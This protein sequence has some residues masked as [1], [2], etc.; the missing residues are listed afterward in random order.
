M[1]DE[2]LQRMIRLSRALKYE[3][4]HARQ[5]GEEGYEGEQWHFKLRVSMASSRHSRELNMA[6]SGVK[7]RRQEA[8]EMGLK[9]ATRA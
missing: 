4:T 6:D 1:I 8:G 5:K 3:K 7:G 9:R 2:T